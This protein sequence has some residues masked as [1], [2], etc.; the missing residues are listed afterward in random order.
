MNQMLCLPSDLEMYSH[1]SLGMN[2]KELTRRVM[3]IYGVRLVMYHLLSKR[4]EYQDDFSKQ[5]HR[6]CNSSLGTKNVSLLY[7]RLRVNSRKIPK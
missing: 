4:R 7:F 2:Y 1:E 6:A 5:H 3:S